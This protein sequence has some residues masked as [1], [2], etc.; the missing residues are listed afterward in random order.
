MAY[1]SPAGDAVTFTW[2]GETAYSPPTGDAVAFEYAPAGV[3]GRMAAP[4]PLGELGAVGRVVVVGRAATP[5]PLSPPM[6]IGDAPVTGTEGTAAVPSPLSAP[7]AQGAAVIV[8]LSRLPGPL[9]VPEVTGR[10]VAVGRLSLSSPLG[11]PAAL[12]RVIRYELRGEVRDHGVLVERRVRA[13]RRDTGA[14][15]GEVDTVTGRF[16]IHVGFEAAEYYLV[17]V[18]LD[19]GATDY[20]PPCANRV[21]SVLAEDAA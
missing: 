15:V 12:G 9:L 14:L 21:V 2:Q 10:V 8:G 19:A 20:A 5:T 11:Q 7:T 17:P 4:T 18:H 16:T 1:T 13:Y 6:A 3:V